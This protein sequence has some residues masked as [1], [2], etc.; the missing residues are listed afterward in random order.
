[1]TKPSRLNLPSIR[2][3]EEVNASS[4]DICLLQRGILEIIN[5]LEK[6][7]LESDSG[8]R[9]SAEI[10][11]TFFGLNKVNVAPVKGWLS[12][13]HS[14]EK[15]SEPGE[16]FKKPDPNHFNIMSKALKQALRFMGNN[17]WVQAGYA[18][19]SFIRM[20]NSEAN[21]LPEGWEDNTLQPS[22]RLEISDIL[23]TRLFLLG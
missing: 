11:S 14:V 21:K 19:G 20:L 12:L 10:F 9:V 4:F 6:Q 7:R 18:Y 16:L 23:S 15:F 8:F 1:M 3:L 17:S 13:K 2:I 5:S 22:E